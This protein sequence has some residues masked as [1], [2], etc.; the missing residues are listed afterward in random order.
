MDLN[1]IN[2][3]SILRH[4]FEC[5]LDNR[6]KLRQVKNL[7]ELVSFKIKTVADKLVEDGVLVDPESQKKGLYSLRKVV[8]P[9]LVN[10]NFP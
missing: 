2:Q 3:D 5:K 4:H 8:D 6:S 1:A 7:E 10:T 9:L